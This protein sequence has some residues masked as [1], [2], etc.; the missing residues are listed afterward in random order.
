MEPKEVIE[1]FRRNVAE[2][3]FD[4]NGRA[5]RKEFWYFILATVVVS[6]AAWF[7]DQILNTGLLRPLVGLALLLPTA[8]LAARRLQDTG[9]TKML[10]LLWLIIAVAM[11][12]LALVT[13]FGIG[14][15]GYGYG[16]GFGVAAAM[17][18]ML[19]G[20]VGLV[21]LAISAVL[22]YFCV[23]PGAKGPNRYGP[24]PLENPSAA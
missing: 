8:A 24:D 20:L 3:Y 19:T 11:Q 16:Y 15:S 2:H 17:F 23:Q 6:I 9:R 18:G 5:S 22:I 12:I 7:I 13:V 4:I 1:V 10:A 14:T 21:W